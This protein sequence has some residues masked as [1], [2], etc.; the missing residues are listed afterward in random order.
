MPS[1]FEAYRMRDGKTPLAEGYFNPIWQDVD[2]RLAALEALKSGWE[3][4]A[5]QGVDYGVER[6]NAALTPVIDQ[7]DADLAAADAAAAQIQLYLAGLPVSYLLRFAPATAATYAYDG[8][9]RLSVTSEAVSGGTRTTTTTYDSNGRVSRQTIAFG[10]HLR[11]EDYTYDTDG[12]L[13]GM[14]AS[15]V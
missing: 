7:L 4:I 11:V 3:A 2:L 9:G 8:F 12:R 14:S 13:T 10:P 5:Q 1:R 6:I 15:E